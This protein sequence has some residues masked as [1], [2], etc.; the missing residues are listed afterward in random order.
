MGIGEPA[1]LRFDLTSLLQRRDDPASS[2]DQA[3][4]L[5]IVALSMIMA[6]GRQGA[7]ELPCAKPPTMLHY[8]RQVNH[9][10][11]VSRREN[12]K[13]QWLRKH[14]ISNGGRRPLRK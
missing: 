13:A 2:R 1:Y 9:Q 6:R 11:S 7:T 10:I 4:C 5:P 14:S 12:G 8:G 3:L